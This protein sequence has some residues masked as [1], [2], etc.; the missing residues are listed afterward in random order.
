MNKITEINTYGWN[1]DHDLYLFLD[2]AIADSKGEEPGTFLFPEK[3]GILWHQGRGF[4]N[5]DAM[6]NFSHSAPSLFPG[7]KDPRAAFNDI[8]W[9]QEKRD[10]QP[11]WK[12]AISDFKAS[13]GGYAGYALVAGILQYLTH[14]E[15][16]PAF[17]KP[18]ISIQGEKGSGKTMT[19]RFGMRLLGFHSYDPISLG[20]TKVGIER[21]FT[22]FCGLPLHIYEWRNDKIDS[23]ML[24]LFISAYNEL[25]QHK[26]IPGAEMLTRATTP[27]TPAIITGECHISDSALK[28]R[29][30]H[31]VASPRHNQQATAFHPENQG[32][33][34]ERALDVERHKRFQ[35]MMQES[36][37]YHR[38][39]RLIIRERK[40]FSRIALEFM[41][42]FKSNP[43]VI[44]RISTSRA[45][46]NI[47]LFVGSIAAAYEI[48][49]G[50][51]LISLPSDHPDFV[52]LQGMN[53]WLINGASS[54]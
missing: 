47:G 23:R 2:C 48:L 30:I 53:D 20:S 41:R 7:A 13:F 51:S 12:A 24:D 44:D 50:H 54:P 25:P 29:Y 18:S 36:H 34:H 43:K 33:E 38:I 9:E 6:A 42:S 28:S 31:I 10:A 26:G 46:E 5:S 4:R 17:G 39:G 32:E 37:H 1:K 49:H 8:D 22:R 52:E 45:R 40:K 21:A 11:I 3:D 16:T 35:R 27:M 14:P 19:T 15:A